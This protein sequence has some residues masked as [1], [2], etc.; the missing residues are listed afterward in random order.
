MMTTSITRFSLPVGVSRDTMRQRLNEVSPQF[1]IIPGLL[2][3]YFLLSD[4]GTTAGG[5]YLW[6]SPSEAHAFSE[7]PLRAMIREKFH[8]EPEITYYETPVIVD[9]LEAAA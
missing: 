8:V 2:R 1:R 6:K 9:N 5:V 7:G 4:D 3:K